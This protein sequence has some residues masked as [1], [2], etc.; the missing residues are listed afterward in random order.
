MF[1]FLSKCYTNV[2]RP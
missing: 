1:S 2:T